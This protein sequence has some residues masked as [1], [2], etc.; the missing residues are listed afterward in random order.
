MNEPPSNNGAFIAKLGAWL[1][2][3]LIYGLLKKDE[4]LRPAPLPQPDRL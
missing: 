4:F 2:L 3:G 1:Q